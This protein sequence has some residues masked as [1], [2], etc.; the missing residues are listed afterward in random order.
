[1]ALCLP[2]LPISHAKF[3]SHTVLG[4]IQYSSIANVTER[5]MAFSYCFLVPIFNLVGAEAQ[6]SILEFLECIKVVKY[7][8]KIILECVL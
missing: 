3:F 6:H 7:A 2:N 8:G 5:D 1:M 4:K